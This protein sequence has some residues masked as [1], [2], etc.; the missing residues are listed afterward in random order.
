MKNLI[1]SLSIL[2]AAPGLALES[3]PANLKN[4]DK[5]KPRRVKIPEKFVMEHEWWHEK[6]RKHPHRTDYGA[7]ECSGEEFLNWHAG[8]IR[9]YQQWRKDNNIRPLPA[10]WKS[11]PTDVARAMQSIGGQERFLLSPPSQYDRLGL[12]GVH[13]EH[14]VHDYIH[15]AAAQVYKDDGIGELQSPRSLYF[16]MIHGLVED[17]RKQWVKAHPGKPQ[18]SNA[19]WK[20]GVLSPDEYAKQGVYPLPNLKN[21]YRK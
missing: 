3:V 17:W 1:F 4:S 2:L 6:G 7:S 18:V 12:M 20:L 5:Q 10:P 21:R 8:F 15:P 11:I 19:C 13:Y 14:I 9:R 16:W